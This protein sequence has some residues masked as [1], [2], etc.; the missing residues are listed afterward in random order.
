MKLLK[1]KKRELPLLK[2]LLMKDKSAKP[3]FIVT[4]NGTSEVPVAKPV[5]FFF[6]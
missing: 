1:I 4:P 2:L 3:D 6:E 5:F